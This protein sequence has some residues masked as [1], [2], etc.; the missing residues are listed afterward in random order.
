M[1]QDQNDLMQQLLA[2]YEEELGAEAIPY[3]EDGGG[4]VDPLREVRGFIE[5]ARRRLA[6]NQPVSMEYTEQ[7]FAMRLQDN[8]IVPVSTAGQ[9]ESTGGIEGGVPVTEPKAGARNKGIDTRN[10]HSWGV[11][12]GDQ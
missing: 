10:S 1:T 9:V 2:E 11:T 6:E 7:G 8:T 12:G 5:F 3:V 4:N